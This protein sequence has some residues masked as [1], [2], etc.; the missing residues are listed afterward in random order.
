MIIFAICLVS[1]CVIG[2]AILAIVPC[3]LSSKISIE[4]EQYMRGQNEGK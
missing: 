2:A 3:I 1:T 4:E